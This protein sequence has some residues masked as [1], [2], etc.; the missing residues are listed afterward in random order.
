MIAE[1]SAEEVIASAVAPTTIEVAADLL[2]AG[3]PASLTV[4]VK[5][6]IPLTVGVP[7]ITPLPVA[8][9]SPAGKLPAVTD[10][11]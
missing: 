5:F 9:V 6:D 10:H 2:C 1:G 4:T 3:T 8:S 7:E 11:V